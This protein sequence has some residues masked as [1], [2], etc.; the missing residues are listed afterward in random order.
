MA[1]EP[2]PGPRPSLGLPHRRGPLRPAAGSAS[3][4][5]EFGPPSLWT[6]ASK[7]KGELWQRPGRPGAGGT[8][9]GA[10]RGAA[11]CR[12]RT[13]PSARRRAQ[14]RRPRPTAPTPT[15]PP[16]PPRRLHP[17]DSWEAAELPAPPKEWGETGLQCAA[18]SPHHTPSGIFSLPSGAPFTRTTPASGQLNTQ[19]S[20]NNR[21]FLLSGRAVAPAHPPFSPWPPPRPSSHLPAAAQRARQPGSPQLPAGSGGWAMVSCAPRRK[22]ALSAKNGE[23]TIHA[24]MGELQVL[25][26]LVSPTN[27]CT[28]LLLQWLNN[29]I[30]SHSFRPS[31]FLI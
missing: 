4:M 10:P 7:K 11:R 30:P 5:A 8:K 27:I 28:R 21:Y 20:H 6:V 19:F 1:P 29:P 15:L 3:A 12:Q 17:P 9:D 16:G 13:P 26:L 31:E 24:F 14:P 23:A 25:N 18:L 22:S 2:A